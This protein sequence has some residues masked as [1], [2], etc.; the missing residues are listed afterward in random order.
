MN[1]IK[2]FMLKVD[3]DIA[4]KKR[5]KI[6][7]EIHSYVFDVSRKPLTSSELQVSWERFS[8]G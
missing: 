8:F 4:I 6:G 5:S 7:A 2:D 3:N 1:L